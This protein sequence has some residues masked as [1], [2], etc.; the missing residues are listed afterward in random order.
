[1]QHRLRSQERRERQR[2]IDLHGA[3]IDDAGGDEV[4]DVTIVELRRQL[5]HLAARR[6][7]FFNECI[8]TARGRDHAEEPVD[9]DRRVVVVGGGVTR[10]LDQQA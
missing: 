1:M 8:N 4:G 5:D 2:L 7:E 9:V 10:G 6:A 3:A